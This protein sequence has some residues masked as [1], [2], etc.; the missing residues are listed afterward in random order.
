MEGR[1]VTQRYGDTPWSW[2]YPSGNHEGL[3]MVAGN[4]FIYAPQDGK[5]VK[6]STGCYGSTLNYAA[7]DH[8]DDIVSYY[9]H[10]R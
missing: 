5:L 9:L 10:I 2:R 3:D 8:G 4:A 6:G 7:I 1:T